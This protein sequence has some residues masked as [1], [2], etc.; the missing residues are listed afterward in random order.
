MA[1]NTFPTADNPNFLQLYQRKK[2]RDV[3]I[4]ESYQFLM[5]LVL[6]KKERVSWVTEFILNEQASCLTVTPPPPPKKEKEREEVKS[7]GSILPLVV[8]NTP[9]L[10]KIPL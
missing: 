5:K 7:V 9:N 6:L 8:L 4:H 2:E 10:A 1:G 3:Q